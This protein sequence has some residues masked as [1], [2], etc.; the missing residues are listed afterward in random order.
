MNNARDNHSK[1]GI[2]ARVSTSAKKQDTENQLIELRKY[3]KASGW[4]YQEFIDNGFSGTKGEDQRPALKALMDAA[5]K[6]QISKVVVWDFSRFARS[7]RM[8]VEAVELFR[9]LGITF[10]SLREG[11]STESSNG[12]LILGIFASL[13]EFERELIRERILLGL[14]KAKLNGKVA[15]P[16]RNQVDLGL[17]QK[18]ARTQTSLRKLGQKHGVSKDT[19]RKLLQQS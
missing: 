5:R 13:A 9:T 7:L 10:I 4:S 12:R 1:C 16:K 19:I 14:Q 8:L 17:L 3:A 11:V 6:K 2:Y 15:G 18:D